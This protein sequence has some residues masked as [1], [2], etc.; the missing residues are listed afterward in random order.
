LVVVNDHAFGTSGPAAR[1]IKPFG[2]PHLDR[3]DEVQVCAQV[4]AKSSQGCV[5]A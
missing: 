1:L 4:S 5:V 3:V 2:F